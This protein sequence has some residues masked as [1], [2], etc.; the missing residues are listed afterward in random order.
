MMQLS[1]IKNNEYI[2]EI[3]LSNFDYIFYKEV[4]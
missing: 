2:T 4:V 1:Y 3:G